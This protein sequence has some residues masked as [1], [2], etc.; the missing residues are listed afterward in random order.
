MGRDAGLN[1]RNHSSRAATLTGSVSAVAS[2]P[3]IEALYMLTTAGRSR[4]S[5]CRMRK[6][7]GSP[8]GVGGVLFIILRLLQPCNKLPSARPPAQDLR[9]PRCI[10]ATPWQIG[11]G[12]ACRRRYH[13][14]HLNGNEASQRT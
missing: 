3:G 10:Y 2:R 6:A 5:P 14:I 7:I 12:L 11:V 4:A 13:A 9:K 1:P 8:E